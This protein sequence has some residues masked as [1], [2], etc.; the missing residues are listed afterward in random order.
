MIPQIFK[1]IF[2]SM[3]LLTQWTCTLH[4]L[5]QWAYSI[6]WTSDIYKSSHNLMNN[7]LH[8]EGATQHAQYACRGN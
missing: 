5:R 8:M 2:I 1:F 6:R 4:L 7:L 3:K